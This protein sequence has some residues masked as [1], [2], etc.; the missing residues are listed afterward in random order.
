MMNRPQ[1]GHCF[2]NAL[3]VTDR[4][5]VD[6]RIKGIEFAE[7]NNMLVVDRVDQW[8]FHKPRMRQA[9]DIVDVNDVA[10][11]RRISH[12]PC[13]VVHLFQTFR[14]FSRN[15]PLRRRIQPANFH[16]S[17]GLTVS[18]DHHVV[19]KLFQTLSK[20][21]EEQ[22]CPAIAYRRYLYERWCNQGDS[23]GSHLLWKKALITA[24]PRS[25]VLLSTH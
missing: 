2:P 18:I 7:R 25:S 19:S 3:E 9:K 11:I 15:R 4:D 12:G 24:F 10:K 16:G 17:F 1:V 20:T 13:R 5:I 6:V 22:L 23:H 21:G 14:E 8:S